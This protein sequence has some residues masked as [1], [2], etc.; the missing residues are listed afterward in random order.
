MQSGKF[1]TVNRSLGEAS[2]IFD[3]LCMVEMNISNFRGMNLCAPLPGV[4]K[5]LVFAPFLT[6]LPEYCDSV[7]GQQQSVHRTRERCKI[8]TTDDIRVHG[9]YFQERC[10]NE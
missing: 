6:E 8:D 7:L 2:F 4:G 10:F 3:H 5:S 9:I 1:Y